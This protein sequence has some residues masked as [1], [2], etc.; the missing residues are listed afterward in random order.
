MLYGTVNILAMRIQCAS[1]SC[2]LFIKR[3]I[4]EILVFIANEQNY[5]LN[6]HAQL[7][8]ASGVR[9]LNFRNLHL[10]IFFVYANSNGSDETV[11]RS[12]F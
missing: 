7:T 8:L 1:G 10:R 6:M 5:Y 2:F 11:Q 4:N 9:R 12:Q 3:N